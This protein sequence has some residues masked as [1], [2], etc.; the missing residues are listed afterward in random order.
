MT[1]TQPELGKL[2][3]LLV[4]KASWSDQTE[5][6]VALALV[7]ALS[8]ADVAASP[9]PAATGGGPGS[10]DSSPAPLPLGTP[11]PAEVAPGDASLPSSS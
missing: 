11:G 6:E 3:R 9:S 10:A 1:S 8:A 7:D 4:S 2:L 5:E